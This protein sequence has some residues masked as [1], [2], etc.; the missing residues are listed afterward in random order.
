MEQI[1]QNLLAVD[2]QLIE[3]YAKYAHTMSKPKIISIG[4]SVAL[5]M[6]YWSYRRATAPP[7]HL[8]H[9]PYVGPF[10]LIKSI[11]RGDSAYEQRR[12]VIAPLLDKAN[13]FYTMNMPVGWTIF[14]TNPEANK[15]I[16]TNMGTRFQRKDLYQKTKQ[17]YGDPSSLVA[18]FI[19]GDH[20]G[21][22]DGPD[23][24]R[25]RKIATPAF[26]KTLPIQTFGQA[27][28]KLIDAINKAGESP[29]NINDLMERITLDIIGLA[30]FGRMKAHDAMNELSG[31]ID[32]LVD[33]RRKEC[34]SGKSN[35]QNSREK[36]LLTLML[37]A[38]M[39][40][41]EKM[42]N[43]ELRDNVSGFLSAGHDTTSNALSYAIYRLGMYKDIQKRTREEVLEILGDDPVDVIPTAEQIKE[44]K[45]ML[46]VIKEASIVLRL[47]GPLVH[48]LG[49]ITTQDSIIAG[50]LIPAN[51]FIFVDV[52]ATHRDPNIWENA[53]QF[54]PD[55]Y[56]V[57]TETLRN[58][59]ANGLVWLPFGYGPHQCLGQNFSLFEQRVI[60]SMLLRKYE[61]ELVNT[62]GNEKEMDSYGFIII[63]PKE[64]QIR[65]KPRY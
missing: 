44:M 36:D 3:L 21:T 13:G 38:E 55:R 7:K 56:N 65:F 2:Q 15:L 63:I 47:D 51:T 57:K 62:A 6:L 20:I 31:M 14:S 26:S 34:Q 40:G 37:E 53:Q 50:Q 61:W 23:W 59:S 46:H 10:D 28:L 33:E 49:R 1:K 52:L 11:I 39:E 12:R 19:G 4:V 42:S 22:L 41:E 60:L 30:G 58:S 5:A 8:R 48:S 9:L 16:L 27:T 45:Y 17:V 25:H 35:E 29:V 18:K 43:Q 54:D 24:R 32:Q 64:I